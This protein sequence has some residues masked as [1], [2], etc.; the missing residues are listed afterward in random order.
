MQ[1][2]TFFIISSVTA[3]LLYF[4]LDSISSISEEDSAENAGELLEYDAVSDGINSVLYD[5]SGSISYTL[6]ARRQY[7]FKDQTSELQEPF[8]RLFRDGK[9]HWNIVAERGYLAPQ[10]GDSNLQEGTIELS[11]DVEIYSLD[12][13]GNRTVLSTEFLTIDPANETMQTDQAVAMH[14]PNIQ[15]R[16][17]GMFAQLDGDEILFIRNGE[18]RYE[19][20]PIP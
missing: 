5:A 13:F 4:G 14:T 16:A 17:I 18:G 9:S 8:I 12:D 3:L 10:N 6:Q 19:I 2:L 20:R 15:Q 11:G 1:K 7:H